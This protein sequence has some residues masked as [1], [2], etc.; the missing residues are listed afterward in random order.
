[1]SMI[2]KSDEALAFLRDVDELHRRG[3]RWSRS[4]L[5]LGL[6]LAELTV[7]FLLGF[8]VA[9]CM[10][11]VFGDIRPLPAFLAACAATAAAIETRR[12]L[13]LR[14]P[15]LALIAS[16][17]TAAS[18]VGTVVLVLAN[19]HWR[20]AL[21]WGAGELIG[22]ALFLGTIHGIYAETVGMLL[23]ERRLAT[24]VGIVGT[25]SAAARVKDDL[26]N[27]DP[28]A[29]RVVG[30]YCVSEE[31]PVSREGLRG[32]LRTLLS[33][34][35]LDIVD[36]VVLALEPG[37]VDGVARVRRALRICTQDLYLVAE[38]SGDAGTTSDAVSV[39]GQSG[40]V[41][42]SRRPVTGAGALIKRAFDIAGALALMGFMA[43]LLAALALAIT[44]D[45]RG[46][47]LFRQLRVG[48]NNRLFYILKFRSMRDDA[49][50]R[51]AKQ[52]TVRGDKRVTRVGRVIRRLSLDE[53]PQLLN[54]LRGEMS[55]VGPRPHAPGT[56]IGGQRV[57]TVV[58][59]YA[60]RHLVR[61]GI[62]G[63]AQVR[64]LRGGL[65]DR[66]QV[67]DRLAADLEYIER[68][69]I[70]LDIRILLGTVV[71]ELRNSRG[72]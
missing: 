70:W 8:V 29:V 49:T 28:L 44:V 48:Y 58:E 22:A 43:P 66:R 56:S 36:A 68:W 39:L 18:A 33:D 63:L 34:C 27:G 52:Q 67:A 10:P 42:I 16:E 19:V 40:L 15:R 54:V 38:R 69:S 35:R 11:S 6:R 25:G 32:T 41:L 20:A 51:L 55:L 31:E 21:E 12:V 59:D 30:C 71:M 47:I 60:R 37:D 14:W 7:I 4:T 50:D 3:A 26:A 23:A 1:M 17:I 9:T 13:R 72:C 5:E 61:P 57:H 45:S 2:A 64:G 24:H 46:P 65:H 53:L 62:T